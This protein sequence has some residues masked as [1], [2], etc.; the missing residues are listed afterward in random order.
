MRLKAEKES[1][2]Q[3]TSGRIFQKK[4]QHARWSGDRKK[5]GMKGAQEKVEHIL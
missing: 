1:A 2:V 4:R 3:R 5:V